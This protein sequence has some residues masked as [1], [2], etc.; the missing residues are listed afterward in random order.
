MVVGTREFFLQKQG[1]LQAWLQV[2][3]QNEMSLP[4]ARGRGNKG[5]AEETGYP[6]SSPLKAA[7]CPDIAL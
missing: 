7:K 4:C 2:M 5:S 6:L 3:L 1:V